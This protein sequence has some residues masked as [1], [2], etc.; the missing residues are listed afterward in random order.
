MLYQKL[1]RAAA[2]Q[3]AAAN[4]EDETAGLLKEAPG[5]GPS[6]TEETRTDEV[7]LASVVKIFIN[8]LS[9][10]LDQM[11]IDDDG[12]KDSMIP[13]DLHFHKKVKVAHDHSGCAPHGPQGCADPSL[14]V[15]LFLH[16]PRQFTENLF[17]GCSL[18]T[19]DQERET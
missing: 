15:S 4:S 5:N 2:K 13:K 17:P 6:G 3:A 1:A 14:A 18:Q 9:R 8:T 11:N 19:C 10:S 16:I 12:D 7:I